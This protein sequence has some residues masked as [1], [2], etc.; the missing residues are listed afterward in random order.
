VKKDTIFATKK[1]E[2]M[3]R[4]AALFVVVTPTGNMSYLAHTWGMMEGGRFFDTIDDHHVELHG[5]FGY[6]LHVP[7]QGM[8]FSLDGSAHA[9]REDGEEKKLVVMQ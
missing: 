5:D 3:E 7:N 1:L 2:G 9:L 4:A 6:I 8:T